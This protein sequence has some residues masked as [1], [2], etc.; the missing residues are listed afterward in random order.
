MA[1]SVAIGPIVDLN[2]Y[3]V[4][5]TRQHLW[6]TFQLSTLRENNT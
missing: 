1:V 4:I 5:Q 2:P 6:R 3:I